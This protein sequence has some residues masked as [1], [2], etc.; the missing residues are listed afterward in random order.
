[1]YVKKAVA[2]HHA[3]GWRSVSITMPVAGAAAMVLGGGARR[4]RN[5]YSSSAQASAAAASTSHSPRQSS[6]RSSSGAVSITRLL[7]NGR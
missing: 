6:V 4:A 2:R 5:R 1:V 7:P 3:P